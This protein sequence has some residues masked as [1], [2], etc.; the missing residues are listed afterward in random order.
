MINA[1]IFFGM[2]LA[3]VTIVVL[4]DWRGR[5]KDREARNGPSW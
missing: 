4:L 5:R 2:I 3:V 1:L